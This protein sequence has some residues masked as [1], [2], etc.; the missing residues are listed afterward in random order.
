MSTGK[1][2]KRRMIYFGSERHGRGAGLYVRG[3]EAE[4]LL[5]EAF[6]TNI[7]PITCAQ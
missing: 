5:Q 7:T 1:Q 2:C 3:Q 4:S 6:E